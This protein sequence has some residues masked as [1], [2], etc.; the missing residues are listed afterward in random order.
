MARSALRLAERSCQMISRAWMSRGC[1][2]AS[3]LSHEFDFQFGLILDVPASLVRQSLSEM[4]I[5]ALPLFVEHEQRHGKHSSDPSRDQRE[6]SIAEVSKQTRQRGARSGRE[7][8]ATALP[9]SKPPRFSCDGDPSQ[10]EDRCGV[11]DYRTL[12]G[13]SRARSFAA[14]GNPLAPD[15]LCQYQPQPK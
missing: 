3:G 12:C 2:T 10:F 14:I 5:S 6:R 15:P 1:L 9:E 11:C 13:G 7:V 8:A 4:P